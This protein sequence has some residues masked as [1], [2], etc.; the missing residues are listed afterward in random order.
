MTPVLQARFAGLL[1]LAVAIAGGFAQL[2]ARSSVLVAGDAATTAQRIRDSEMLLRIGFLADV[3]NVV[4]FLG[5]A[6]LLYSLLAPTSRGMAV[7]F[8]ALN[9]IAAGIMGLDLVNHAGALVVATDPSYVTALGANGADALAALF[10]DLHRWGYL[11]AEVFFGLW[12]LPLGIAVRR[13]GTF[14]RILGTGLVIGAL[15]YMASFALS[16]AAPDT[17]SALSVMIAIPGGLAELIF[18]A[19][20]LVRGTNAAAISLPAPLMEGASS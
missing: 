8:L 13:S 15:A 16:F 3:V 10:L 14:P 6:L 20:L 1:Y 2:V 11:V 19:W 4:A 18:M 5:V 12:L 9:A 7:A 17:E